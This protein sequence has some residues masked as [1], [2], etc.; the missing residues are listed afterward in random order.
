M[1][2]K[3]AP[4]PDPEAIAHA[5]AA[6]LRYVNDVDPGISRKGTSPAN[7]SYH[8][9]DGSEVR[10]AHILK[11]IRALAIPPAWTDV[12]ICPDPDGHIQATGRDA[13]GRK[14]Y[15]Y[16]PR[17]QEVRDESKYTR[18]IDFARALPKIRARI[19]RDLARPGIGRERVLAAVVRLLERS[20]IRVGNDEY[21]KSNDSYGLT[22][23]RDRHVAV[24]GNSIEFRFRAKSGKFRRLE[25]DSPRL[26]KVVRACQDLPGQELFQ[27]RDEDG[28][29]RDVTSNDVNAYLREI[30][31]EDFTAKDFRTWAGTVGA[32]LALRAQELPESKAAQKRALNAAIDQVA[33]VLGNTRAI[34]RKAYVHPQ[35]FDGFSDGTLAKALSRGCKPTK[36]LDEAE[37]AVLN[38]LC[39]GGRKAAGLRAAALRTHARLT[40]SAGAG[41][42]ELRSR[43]RR[44]GPS[45][46]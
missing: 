14:Q 40:T 1:A 27:Y 2:S 8:R 28:T 41:R 18:M 37:T 21:A 44:L 24:N 36:G 10:A 35:V 38:F 33:G 19:D 5:R 30:T 11:R 45:R 43:R 6:K 39:A 9:P 22:T 12:W 23:L 16:H 4:S 3:H 34:C 29:I 31:G 26:S 46:R 7:F 17:W 20:L 15:R 25:L 42:Y 13:K 32:A